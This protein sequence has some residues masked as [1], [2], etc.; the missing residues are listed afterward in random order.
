MVT[1]L[2]RT[3]L[4]ICPVCGRMQK[5]N[6]DIFSLSGKKKITYS[7]KCKNSH[8]RLEV[9]K[10]KSYMLYAPCVVCNEEHIF[11]IGAKI[12]WSAPQI[13]FG[14]PNVDFDIV[15]V[16]DKTSMNKI[17]CDFT[18]TKDAFDIGGEYFYENPILGDV[19][20]I[21]DGMLKK[22]KIKCHCENAKINKS[23]FLDRVELVCGNCHTKKVY[24]AA[25]IDDINFIKNESKK[26]KIIMGENKNGAKG[27]I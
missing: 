9:G 7:C 15:N 19:L 14:C 25:C 16:G 11:K 18:K 3:I 21:V 10:N 4:Y 23:V 20:D 17:F 2:K 12:F 13:V 5:I 24:D 1:D 26:K 27:R 8:I 22:K 6:I